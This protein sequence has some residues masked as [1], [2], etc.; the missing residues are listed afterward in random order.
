MVLEVDDSKVGIMTNEGEFFYVVKNNILPE[1]GDEYEGRLYKSKTFNFKPRVFLT[2]ASIVLICN[3]LLVYNLFFKVYDTYEVNMNPSMKL[4][5]NRLGKII[6]TEGL[7]QE[8]VTL[9]SNVNV[10]N[11]DIENGLEAI[12]DEAK[13]LNYLN[14]DNSKV[15]IKDS[16]NQNK[17]FSEL[18]KKINDYVEESKST[19]DTINKSKENS[20]GKDKEDSDK[21]NDTKDNNTTNNNDNN[22]NKNSK[23]INNVDNNKHT[24]NNTTN[25]N[26][27]NNATDKTTTNSSNK[28]TKEK[29]TNNSKKNSYKENSVENNDGKKDSSNNDDKDNSGNK[30]SNTNE[31]KK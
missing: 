6:K 7:N 12:V 15:S 22:G 11:K 19:K 5:T 21:V 2:A 26:N 25:K 27:T 18:N 10:K 17:D 13:A 31:H 4:Y 9:L 8:G 16:K 24:D 3:A 14:E 28:D 20:S 23:D 30:H 1:L 29:D